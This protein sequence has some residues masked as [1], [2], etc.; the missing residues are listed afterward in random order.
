MKITVGK[1]AHLIKE[2]VR[3]VEGK[4]ELVAERA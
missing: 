1:N 4:A 2:V 3:Y